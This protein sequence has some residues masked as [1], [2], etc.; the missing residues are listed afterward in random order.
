MKLLTIFT[1]TTTL[2]IISSA[3]ASAISIPASPA[4]QYIHQLTRDLDLHPDSH[5]P[6]II[7]RIVGTVHCTP[8]KSGIL[9]AKAHDGSLVNARFS[10]AHTSAAP[11]KQ[12]LITAAGGK[13]LPPQSFTFSKCNSTITGFKPSKGAF[14]GSKD[15]A[16]SY[17]QLSPAS[18]VGQRCVGAHVLGVANKP[19][20]IVADDCSHSDDSSQLFQ[21]WELVEVPSKQGGVTSYLQFVGVLSDE[22]DTSNAFEGTYTLVQRT[23]TVG[24]DD[25]AVDA[26]F[27]GLEYLV[28][29]A[30][31]NPYQLLLV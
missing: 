28:R 29:Q 25:H 12:I 22:A 13:P 15:T 17:G 11:N 23:A 20:Y 14:E 18:R 31:S 19:Q 21:Q 10:H 6:T 9:K 16:F 27:V 3:S 26:T 8:Y 4:E 7:E 1:T 24:S 5:L 2:L 30:V